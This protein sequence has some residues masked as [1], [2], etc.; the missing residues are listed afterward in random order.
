VAPSNDPA[1]AKNREVEWQ[2]TAPDPGQ[3]RHW[4]QTN[5][6]T[7]S[8]IIEPRPTA[9][10]HDVYFDTDDWRIYRAGYALRLR[11]QSNRQEVTLKS[12]HSARP[13]VMDRHE[14]TEPLHHGAGSSSSNPEPGQGRSLESTAESILSLR[15]SV[16]APVRAVAGN[17]PLRPLFEVRTNRQKFEVFDAAEAQGSSSQPAK[18]EVAIDETAISPPHSAPQANLQRVEIEARGEDPAPVEKLVEVLTS[19]C[20]LERSSESKFAAGL[21]ASGLTPMV[22]P[23]STPATIETSTPIDEVVLAS[24]RRH[25]HAWIQHE[26]A[27]RFG[28]NPAELHALRVAARHMDTFLGVFADHL[29]AKLVRTRDTLK[30]LL[31]T[32]GDVRD[33]DLQI[34]DVGKFAASLAEPQR[35]ALQPLMQHLHSQ[36]GAARE[37]MLRLLD[38]RST[39]RWKERLAHLLEQPPAS[40]D[41]RP[42][43]TVAPDLIRARYRKIRK[44]ANR[45][46]DNSSME[47]Y[48]KVRIRTKKLRYAVEAL[49][50]LYGK[51]ADEMARVLRKVQDHLGQMHDA[52][53]ACSRMTTLATDAAASF[54]PA[55]AFAMGR[56][57]QQRVTAVDDRRRRFAKAYR[58]L[59]KKKWQALRA[60]LTPTQESVKGA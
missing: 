36:R 57:A 13:D 9:R 30:K 54:P 44:A 29:P 39:E 5:R 16:G 10:I 49:A 46:T 58:K 2:L 45:L 21:K 12:L 8:F 56:Y 6:K 41:S 26:P 14:L 28:E 37:R 42:A 38:T 43:A 59:R 40:P 27:A 47:D 19:E 20:G 52:D 51:P 3:V 55:T 23:E 1:N 11:T 22:A 50:P 48:H 24:L 32:F 17:R 60:T 53:V 18:A 35:A 33:L 15:G 25:W 4:L 31:R 34:A 7:D